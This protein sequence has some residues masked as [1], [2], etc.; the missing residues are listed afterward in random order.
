MRAAE[1]RPV[2][3]PSS[4][5]SNWESQAKGLF[6][7][8]VEIIWSPFLCL[9]EATDGNLKVEAKLKLKTT[10]L[11]EAQK[12]GRGS[13]K[14]NHTSEKNERAAWRPGSSMK[15]P[16]CRVPRPRDLP[17]SAPR[18]CRPQAHIPVIPRAE[19]RQKVACSSGIGMPKRCPSAAQ[20]AQS[21][22][23]EG[24]KKYRY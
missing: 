6:R 19:N 13:L 15:E 2:T 18:Q 8:R 17:D 20:S 12:A 11:P 22:R 21:C 14:L 1:P 5:I 10:K 7:T 3:H 24:C 23:E 4:Q 16:A 9:I